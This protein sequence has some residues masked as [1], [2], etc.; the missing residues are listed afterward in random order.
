MVTGTVGAGA[1]GGGRIVTT[2]GVG[3]LDGAGA[4]GGGSANARFVLEIQRATAT[5]EG[6]RRMTR[7]S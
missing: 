4:G 1:A 3:P 6:K 2:G 5:P 7:L